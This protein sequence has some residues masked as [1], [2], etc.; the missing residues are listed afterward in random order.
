MSNRTNLSKGYTLQF[1]GSIRRVGMVEHL[2]KIII[3]GRKHETL[4]SLSLADQKVVGL[5]LI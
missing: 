3:K 4:G 2:W 1:L 5:N